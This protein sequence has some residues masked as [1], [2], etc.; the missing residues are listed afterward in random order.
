MSNHLIFNCCVQIRLRRCRKKKLSLKKKTN[1]TFR[2]REIEKNKINK[3]AQ[4]SV[5]II[6]VSMGNE[7]HNFYLQQPITEQLLLLLL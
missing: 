3:K 1:T 2:M 5:D 6:V 4:T 7:T